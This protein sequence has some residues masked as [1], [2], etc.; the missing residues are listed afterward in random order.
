[1]EMLLSGLT[2]TGLEAVAWV[3]A[4][5]A[6]AA[7]LLSPRAPR[8]GCHLGWAYP[9]EMAVTSVALLVADTAWWRTRSDPRAAAVAGVAGLWLL[10]I[11]Y[12]DAAWTLEVIDV[13]YA[14]RYQGE[15]ESHRAVIQCWTTRLDFDLSTMTEPSR[16]ACPSDIENAVVGRNALEESH[17][18]TSAPSTSAP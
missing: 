2:V 18:V 6:G 13:G 1:M 14:K 5:V 4:V 11:D 10:S 7:L 16:V 12:G 8:L 15:D 9:T 3:V 17:L